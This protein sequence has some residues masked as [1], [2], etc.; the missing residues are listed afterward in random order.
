MDECYAESMNLRRLIAEISSR[1]LWQVT[2]VYLFAG[3]GAFE[4][5][6][7]LT[8]TAGLPVWFP[9]AALAILVLFLPVVLA[10]AFIGKNLESNNTQSPEHKSS[11]PDVYDKPKNKLSSTIPWRRAFISGAT[12]TLIIT[13][14]GI[15]FFSYNDSSET[16]QIAE[17]NFDEAVVENV[18][19]SAT[20]YI[21]LSTMPSKAEVTYRYIS[22][23]EKGE[24]ISSNTPLKELTLPI[25]EYLF[26]ISSDG[27]NSLKFVLE[28][29]VDRKQ[30]RE[31]NLTPNSSLTSGMAHVDDGFLVSDSLSLRIPEFLIDQTEITNEQFSKFVNSGGYK[32]GSVWKISQNHISNKLVDITGLP[33]PRNWSGSLYPEKSSLLPVSSITWYE[34]D[35]YCRWAGKRLPSYRQWWGAALSD[36]EYQYPWGNNVTLIT[37]RANFE[38]Q[39]SWDVGSHPAG[40]SKYGVYDLAGNVR[41]WVELVDFDSS[42]ALTLGGSW[43]DPV[44]IFDINMLEEL[45]LLFTGENIG[46]RCSRII[47]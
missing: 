4:V 11:E 17:D 45:P 43:Q 2:G 20:G 16:A 44:Y 25:G 26:E 12:I 22:D 15:L 35:A 24:L 5:I 13:L 3:W 34:A 42:M 6:S 37:E 33:G 10:T 23:P 18:L 28:I 38:S 47:D 39:G 36:S 31:V 30:N 21:S 19:N 14:I 27:Y 1:S 41:E 8:E 40:A 9:A 32:N 7:S 29:A 46:F